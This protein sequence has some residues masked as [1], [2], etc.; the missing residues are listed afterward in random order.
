MNLLHGFTARMTANN[1]RNRLQDVINAVVRDMEHMDFE[2]SDRK[3]EMEELAGLIVQECIDAI[4]AI[5]R[6]TFNDI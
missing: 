5:D 1:Y 6:L 3:D 2:N 4:E